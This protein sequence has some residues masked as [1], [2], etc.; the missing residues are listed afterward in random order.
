MRSRRSRPSRRGTRCRRSRPEP[1]RCASAPRDPARATAGHP[2]PGST[3]IDDGRRRSDGS[4]PVCGRRRPPGAAR[5]QPSGLAPP[6]AAHAW[7]AGAPERR[8]RGTSAHRQRL[9]L[10]RR[11]RPTA[12][13]RR[14]AGRKPQE[15]AFP[16]GPSRPAGAP[17]GGGPRACG[18]RVAT[19]SASSRRRRCTSVARGSLLRPQ[20]RVGTGG[21]S[22]LGVR[23]TTS[24][25]SGGVVFFSL[26]AAVGWLPLP[27]PWVAGEGVAVVG[28]LLVVV[29]AE[30]GELVE[31]G[32]SGVGP[33]GG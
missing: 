9:P 21:P 2:T 29:V 22:G 19:A 33:A 20:G 18:G 10:R 13:S 3:S 4:L 26:A 28:L 11:T 16:R 30:A 12:A 6:S 31:G 8:R 24:A 15:A 14:A 5:G 25:P 27:C 1:D 17:A 23:P 7:C 32:S